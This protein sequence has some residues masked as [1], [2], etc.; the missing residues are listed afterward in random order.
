[1]QLTNDNHEFFG[2]NSE[3]VNQILDQFRMEKMEEVEVMMAQPMKPDL[4]VVK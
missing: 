1:M 3:L 2:E 4:H